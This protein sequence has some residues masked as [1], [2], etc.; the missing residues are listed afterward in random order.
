M[1]EEYRYFVRQNDLHWLWWFL[2]QTKSPPSDGT[3]H[4]SDELD[5]YGKPT[6]YKM[7]PV[8]FRNLVRDKQIEEISEEEFKRR[9]ALN[10]LELI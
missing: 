2:R 9:V 3:A 5:R 8:R 10:K 6:G 4:W 7:I 1:K